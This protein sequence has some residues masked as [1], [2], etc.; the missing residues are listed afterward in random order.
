MKFT[1]FSSLAIWASLALCLL[2]HNPAMAQPPRG[3]D[4]EAADLLPQSILGCMEISN[5]DAALKTIFDHPIR[6]RIEATPA[7]EAIV[8][9]GALKQLQVGIQAFEAN[10]EQAW[11]QAI[12]TL[13]DRGITAALDSSNGGVGVLLHSSSVEALERFYNFVL[14]VQLLQGKAATQGEYREFTAHSVKENLK[15][16]RMHDWLLLT[17]KSEFGKAVIDRY[18]DR[19]EDSLSKSEGFQQAW[20]IAKANATDSRLVSGYVNVEHIRQAGIAKEFYRERVENLLF[21]VLIGGVLANLKNTPFA[22]LAL[23]LKSD[24]ASLQ[25]AVPHKREWESPREYYF[26]SPQLAAAPNMLDVGDRLFALSAH[27]DLSQ[28]WLRAGDLLTDKGNDELA[29][30]DTQLT[31]FFA[32][33]DFG[34][35]ILGALQ[36]DLQIVGK[37]QNFEG[38]LPQPAIKLP[39]FAVQF[40]MKDAADTQPELRRVF[41][42]LIGFFNITSAMNGQPQL[43]LGIETPAGA[44]LVTATFVPKRDQRE[45]REAAIQFNFSPTL[46]F[47]GDRV[48]LSSSTELARELVATGDN[49]ARKEAAEP[50]PTN[51]IAKLDVASLGKILQANRTQ[52]VT[53]NMLEKGHSEESAAAE[54]DLVLEIVSYFRTAQLS[55]D[56]SDTALKVVTT[57]EVISG[58]E[59]DD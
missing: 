7:Y 42:S 34:E 35:D 14:A 8:K 3:E 28:M 57:I 4:C 30:A 9:A 22:S 40:K 31:T 2:P 6:S 47:A 48:I 29:V 10:M 39:S 23:D 36:S 18:L 44:Q 41:Q 19:G 50:M 49:A 38:V 53:N 27:R 56:V 43:D 24:V 32:G 52:L 13:G 11:Q 25:V 46:A 45:N 55:L 21:E 5:L 17:N 1:I 54:I 51:T 12:A 16:V 15:M 33:R 58:N 59:N 37:T 26:G 20:K